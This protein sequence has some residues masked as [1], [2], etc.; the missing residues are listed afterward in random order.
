MGIETCVGSELAGFWDAVAR[1]RS[2]IAPIESFDVSSYPCKI[3]GEVDHH[4]EEF[5]SVS[6]CRRTSRFQQ[7]GLTSALRARA[8]EIRADPARIGVIVGSGGGGLPLVASIIDPLLRRGWKSIDRFAML[9]TLP[10]MAAG[11]I[12]QTVGA[13]GPVLT[14]CT[15]CSASTDAIGMGW[16]LIRAG[17]VD[18][19]VV[20]GVDI[21]VSDVTHACF[22]HLR[23]LSTTPPERAATASRPFDLDRNGMVPAEGA[24]TVILEAADSPHQLL[25]EPLGEILGAASTCDAFHPVM[26]RA[27]AGPASAAIR[28]ALVAADVD[29]AEIALVSAHGTS[30]RL[31]DISETQAAKLA[32]GGHAFA[33][34]ITATKSVVGHAGGA[35]GVIEF[36]AMV[37]ALSERFAPPTANLETPDP[38][39]DLDYVSNSGRAIEGELGLKLSFGFGGQNSVLVFRGSRAGVVNVV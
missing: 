37:V 22:S 4:P 33:V 13:T 11:L 2:G 24:G 21:C 12:A 36:V 34:P 1:G 20:T 6:E 16:R 17:E 9:K 25:G 29:P 23:V 35:C 32:L 38:Q 28:Q 39:C 26:P 3:G 30:T 19:A 8:N 18:V 5:L 14:V 27:D 10:N 15:A 31:N 7:L